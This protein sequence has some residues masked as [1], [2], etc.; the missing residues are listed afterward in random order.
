MRTLTLCILFFISL[1]SY[2]QIKID[3]KLSK[4][5]DELELKLSSGEFKAFFDES[6][7]STREGIGIAIFTKFEIDTL[8]IKDFNKNALNNI[9]IS[10]PDTGLEDK[11]SDE[12]IPVPYPDFLS[13]RLNNNKLEISIGLF[14]PQIIYTIQNSKVESYYEEYHK[15]DNILQLKLD[16][17]KVSKLNIP[18][19]TNK[20]ILSNKEF[21]IGETL[22]GEIEFE[23]EPYYIHE[24]NYGFK[25]NYIYQ[26]VKGALMFK[27]PISDLQ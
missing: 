3:K 23:T 27:V 18:I 14:N 5:Y 25:F 8:N 19:H 9:K 21:N 1:S 7:K 11:L 2:S 26:R 13:A 24:I 22:S 12:K 10:S 6:E 17:P 20:F 4:K 15:D 16:Q